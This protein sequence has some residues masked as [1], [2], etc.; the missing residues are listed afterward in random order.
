MTSWAMTSNEGFLAPEAAEPTYPVAYAL[1][2]PGSLSRVRALIRIVLALPYAIVTGVLLWIAWLIS[3][4]GWISI[5]LTATYDRGLW[6]FVTDALTH[7]AR[8]LSYVT[9]LRDE[10]PPFG[11]R[12]YPVEFRI[13]FVQRRS[14]ARALFRALLVLPHLCVFYVLTVPWQAAV[15][16]AWFTILC[17]GRY[18]R[19]I[20]LLVEGINR[21]Y[22]RVMAYLMLLTDQYPPF[23]LGLEEPRPTPDAARE[24]L[25][26]STLDFIQAEPPAPSAIVDESNVNLEPAEGSAAFHPFPSHRPNRYGDDP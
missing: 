25:N 7:Q 21:W 16:I 22:L 4:V 18:P 20:W 14:R 24:E 11:D 12:P 3:F 6:Q 19:G 15:A 1:P 10:F 23:S 26:H 9:L 2:Y 17:T 13:T 8:L 5:V